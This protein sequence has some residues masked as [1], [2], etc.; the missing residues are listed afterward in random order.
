[1]Q[2]VVEKEKTEGKQIRPFDEDLP[3]YV[4]KERLLHVS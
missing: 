4:E 1:M 2:K 3:G